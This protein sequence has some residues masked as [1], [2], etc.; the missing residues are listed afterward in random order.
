LKKGKHVF[1]IFLNG[2]KGCFKWIFK[3]LWFW[4]G[5]CQD[6]WSLYITNQNLRASSS[7]LSLVVLLFF[8]PTPILFKGNTN[9]NGWKLIYIRFD[10]LPANALLLAQKFNSVLAVLSSVPWYALWAGYLVVYQNLQY[11]KGPPSSAHHSLLVLML[12]CPMF[13]WVVQDR[14]WW[15]SCLHQILWY[16]DKVWQCWLTTRIAAWE[17]SLKNVNKTIMQNL[18]KQIA[19]EYPDFNG[20][21][22]LGSCALHTTQSI[23]KRYRLLLMCQQKV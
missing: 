16:W 18:Q 1:P 14:T 3:K 12:Y 9:R 21:V 20:F 4:R 8:R 7:Y 13:P 17:V 11:L 19:N 6:C 5:F 15:L 22:D 2:W 23:Q 10:L